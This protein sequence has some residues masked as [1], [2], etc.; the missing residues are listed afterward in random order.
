MADEAEVTLE[1]LEREAEEALKAEE[2][3]ASD[4]SEEPA[5]AAGEEGEESESEESAGTEQ[6][7][8]SGKKMVEIPVQKLSKLREQRRHAKEEQDKLQK[9]NDELVRQ[10]SLMGAAGQPKQSSAVP[11]LE[12]CDYDES[13]YQAEMLKWNRQ[14]LE[15]SMNEIE[16]NRL[17]QQ[18]A[19][20]IHHQIE[21]DVKQHY[22]RVQ[23]IGIDA[24]AFIPAEQA[25][26]DQ[27]G[28]VA[29]D[30]MISAIGEGSERVVYHLGLNQK[31]RDKVA[32]LVQQ[33]PSGLRA[34]T[35]LGRMAVKLSTEPV[36][37]T[38]SQAPAADRPI[39]GSSPATGSAVLKRLDKLSKQSNR[40]QF[41]AYK[42]QLVAAGQS[43]LLRKHGYM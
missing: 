4:E 30:Q 15:Q 40:D 11:S 36:K 16:Q 18:R 19:A 17:Q 10:L 27:F 13:K 28:D 5:K 31:E 20:L 29:V 23:D 42:K 38:I 33:D 3:P 6:A 14:N 2:A 21:A 37:G 39:N 12:S 34:M 25:L 32:E 41:R 35:Y 8:P 26:R 7:A 43:D 24:D 22:Q 9:Q 1:A